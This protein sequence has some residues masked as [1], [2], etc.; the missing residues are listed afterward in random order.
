MAASTAAASWSAGTPE[1]VARNKKSYTAEA[2]RKV[3]ERMSRMSKY[4]I[5]PLDFAGLKTVGL[6]G[7]RRQ[8]EGGGFRHCRISQGSGIAGLLDSLPHIL[9]GDSFPRRGRRHRR[10]AG[11]HGAPSSGAWAGT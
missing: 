2:L 7:A 5:Q 10:R 4:A 8:G 9:A 3:S 6:E 1:Q 11:A